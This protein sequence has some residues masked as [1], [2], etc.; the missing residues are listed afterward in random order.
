MK[1]QKSLWFTATRLHSLYLS[2]DSLRHKPRNENKLYNYTVCMISPRLTF[3]LMASGKHYQ[4]LQGTIFIWWLQNSL[5]WINHGDFD[6]FFFYLHAWCFVELFFFV[7]SLARSAKIDREHG[8]YY[9]TTLWV[10]GLL[11]RISC[12]LKLN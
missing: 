5:K 7:S 2:P 6:D 9:K 10:S 11:C 1:I 12:G 3:I 8:E 4:E